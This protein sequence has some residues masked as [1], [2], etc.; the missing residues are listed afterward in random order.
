MCD[1][2]AGTYLFI[3]AMA[4][5]RSW[6]ASNEGFLYLVECSCTYTVRQEAE[7]L[8]SLPAKAPTIK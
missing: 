7:R 8:L 2:E 4:L 1:H 3:Y 6:P 5:G